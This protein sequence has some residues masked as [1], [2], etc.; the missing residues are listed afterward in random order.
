MTSQEFYSLMD[1]ALMP[2]C[3]RLGLSRKRG[4]ISLWFAELPLGWFYFEV[5]KGVKNPFIPTLGG[6]F[7]VYCHVTPSANQKS[8]SLE[9]HISYM[10]Y[11]S[12]ADLLVIQNLRDRALKKILEQKPTDEFY[13]MLLEIHGPLLQMQ[14]GQQFYR[15]AIFSV[16]YLDAED[17]SAWGRFFASRLEQTLVGSKK[18]PVFFMRRESNQ[19]IPL[20]KSDA[21]PA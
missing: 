3:K 4:T 12:D 21:P 16:P 13:R 11:F 19:S 14:M 17:V 10:E 2:E 1:N 20:T 7:N 5:S 9:N 18:N 8:C 6:R 15:H